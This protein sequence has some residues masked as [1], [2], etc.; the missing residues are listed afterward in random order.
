LTSIGYSKRVQIQTQ[1]HHHWQTGPQ[2]RGWGAMSQDGTF[3]G[4]GHLVKRRN[5]WWWWGW[6][7][8][9]RPGVILPH[10]GTLPA[11]TPAQQYGSHCSQELNSITAVSL[12]LS[13][14]L[15][16]LFC[17]GIAKYDADHS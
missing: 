15:H 11:D 10:V 9:T 2:Q 3:W 17:P 5:S 14:E 7:F 1:Q 13:H 8:S 12:G 16:S 4:A 6:H